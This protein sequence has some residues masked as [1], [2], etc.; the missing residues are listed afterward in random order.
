MAVKNVR[1][2]KHGVLVSNLCL[3]TMNFGWHTSEE[4]SFAIMVEAGLR[5][6]GALEE[7]LF[8]GRGGEGWSRLV[9]QLYTPDAIRAVF[10]QAFPQER[11]QAE[12]AEEILAFF[13]SETGQRVVEGELAAWRA[14]TDPEVEAAANEFYFQRLAAGDSRL[15]LLTRLIESNDFVDLNVMAALNSN[16]AFLLAMS[17]GGAYEQQ[18]A[19]DMI[20][21]QVWQ[22]EPRIREDTTLWLYSFPLMAYND[23]SDAEMEAYIAFSES[24]AGQVY[25][26]ALF[27]GFDAVF[28]EMSYLLGSA[29]ANYMTGEPL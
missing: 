3:G 12:R 4:E 17:D 13:T 7:T 6:A 26:S 29:A 27:A 8:P 2:G 28:R 5:D 24:E 1:L 22:Q 15:D 20:L 19:Q 21:S 10:E 16:Y 14:I 25:N 9:E 23:L 11:M 18:I